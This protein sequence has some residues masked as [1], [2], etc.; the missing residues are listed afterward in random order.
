MLTISNGYDKDLMV[1]E[2]V[3]DIGENIKYDFF[4]DIRRYASE[5]RTL[6]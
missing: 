2:K 6:Y 3:Y 5:N 4:S 1:Y